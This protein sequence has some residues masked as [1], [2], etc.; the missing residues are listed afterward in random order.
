VP[1]DAGSLGTG[2]LPVLAGELAVGPAEGVD[3]GPPVGPLALGAA[4]GAAALGVAGVLAGDPGCPPVVPVMGPVGMEV[5][6]PTVGVSV[7][8]PTAASSAPL[9]SELH[10]H[11]RRRE[12]RKDGPH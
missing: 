9:G 7:G 11:T 2:A 6:A 1:G 4:E 8:E 5:G 3:A 10:A 12:V